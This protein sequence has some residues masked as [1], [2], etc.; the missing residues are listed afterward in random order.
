MT[1]SGTYAFAPTAGEAFL[2]AF[3]MC[4]IR[5]TEITLEHLTDATFQANM[6]MVD[7]SNKNP[8]QFTLETQSVPLT[9]STATY[10]LSART[11]ALGAAYIE[12][13]SGTVTTARVLAPMSAYE[14]GSIPNKDNEGFPSSYWLNLLTPTP[15]I[16]LYLTPD[17][18]LTY[19]LKLQTFRQLQDIDPASGET[20][21]APY[22][23]L[24][25]FT[26][27]LAARLAVNYAPDRMAN[28]KTLFEERFDLAAAQ[29]QERVNTYITPGLSGY[30]S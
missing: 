4:G 23:F 30:F 6:Q 1:T 12:T 15:Q 22:R 9:A 19:T 13:T 5:R 8:H 28:L 17:D 2:A 18:S 20:L 25:A 16:S 14:Y 3:S 27:G 29:D 24:D 11:I 21:D 7:F 26:T 10:S